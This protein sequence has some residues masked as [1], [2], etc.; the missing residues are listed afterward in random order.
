MRRFKL[1][2]FNMSASFDFDAQDC[3]ISDISG[4]GNNYDI[5]DTNGRVTNMIS[6]FPDISFLINFG[7]STNAYTAYNTFV[8]FISSN[9]KRKLILEYTIN[10]RTIYAEV[11]I[12][13]L[14]KTQKTEFNILSETVLFTRKSYWYT[15]NSGNLPADITN[16]MAEDIPVNL[17]ITGPTSTDFKITLSANSNIVS[18]VKLKNALI[19]GQKLDID[20]ECIKV[21]FIENSISTNGYNK[22]DKATDTFIIIKTGTYTLAFSGTVG[23]ITYQYKKWVID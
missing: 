16:I 17:V 20:A 21:Y 19:A 7:I 14:P 22:I 3:I 18:E 13:T 5:E 10:G 8:N 23:S 12:R 1:F 4:L 9:G 2:N 15:I 11:W 6:N